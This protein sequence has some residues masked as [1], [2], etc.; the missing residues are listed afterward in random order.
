MRLMK[1]QVAGG[2]TSTSA[3][4]VPPPSAASARSCLFCSLQLANDDEKRQ[5][6]TGG[7]SKIHVDERLQNHTPIA[8]AVA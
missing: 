3:V 8:S 2:L 6:A 5:E 1:S 4:D 7:V